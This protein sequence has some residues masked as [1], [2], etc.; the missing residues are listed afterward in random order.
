MVEMLG[1][2]QDRPEDPSFTEEFISS[3][4]RRRTAWTC[5]LMENLLSGGR[6]RK[7]VLKAEDMTIQLPCETEQFVFGIPV[8][9]ERLDGS[10]PPLTSN[11]PTTSTSMLGYTIKVSKI[12][13]D[14]AKWACSP[15]SEENP[16]DPG[17]ESQKLSA[18]LEDW[19]CR[20]P[21]R[22]K[23]SHSSLEAHNSLS[24]G[25]GFCYM[26][27]IYLMAVMFLY[28]PYLPRLYVARGEESLGTSLA[29]SHGES[30]PEKPE[31]QPY[32]SDRLYTAASTV[33]DMCDEI[34]KFGP[35]F[36]RGLVPWIGFTVYTAVGVMLYVG[37]FPMD[38]DSISVERIRDKISI[39]C[40]M[41]TEMKS[42]WPMAGR[43][44]SSTPHMTVR[45]LGRC[46]LIQRYSSSRFD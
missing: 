40:K 10:F 34:V 35:D 46:Q 12:W 38:F 1:L 17:S 27:C 19:R 22:F 42:E 36:R 41:L 2:C 6:C 20:L 37:Y 26:H 25:Q 45:R 15:V 44:V 43:W 31:W 16:C 39:G 30:R 13:G 14:V 32:A 11:I 23:Y 4:E 5:F 28:R 7:R 33:C 18:A 9:C 24:Q 3:E 29:D 21:D 8:R